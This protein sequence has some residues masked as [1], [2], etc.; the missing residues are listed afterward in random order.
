MKNGCVLKAID[1]VCESN[2][3]NKRIS[4]SQ[5]PYNKYDI[6]TLEVVVLF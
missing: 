4:G 1:S 3:E 2:L 6:L 5:P